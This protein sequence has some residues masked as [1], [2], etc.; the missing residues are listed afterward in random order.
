MSFDI[1]LSGILTIIGLGLSVVGVYLTLSGNKK[2][3][4]SKTIDWTQ[5]HV[6]ARYISKMVVKDKFSPDFILAPG[7]R[8]SIIGQEIAN[9][10]NEE[11]PVITGYVSKDSIFEKKIDNDFVVIQANQ[12]YLYLPICIKSLN[13][14]NVLIV[15]D[16]I[17]SG[18]SLVQIKKALFNLEY[19]EQQIRYCTIAVTQVP[20]KRKH[21]PNYYYKLVDP[22]ECYFPW[23]KA[24]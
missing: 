17:M 6:G 16:W 19:K 14:K 11:I 5:I 23:G 15:Q 24:R 7:P 20:L 22:D 8:S 3:K 12:W 2:I 21:R 13:D 4:D 18:E 9:I 1:T 10:L